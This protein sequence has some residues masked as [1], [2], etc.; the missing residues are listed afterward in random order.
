MRREHAD[1]KQTLKNTAQI[2]EQLPSQIEELRA[3]ATVIT[4]AIVALTLVIAGAVIIGTTTKLQQSARQF[5]G[6]Q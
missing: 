3:M 6:E 1:L 5:D 2:T 4:V